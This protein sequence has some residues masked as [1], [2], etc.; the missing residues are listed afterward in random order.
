MK[1]DSSFTVKSSGNIGQEL[2]DA[3]GTVVCWTTDP[4]LAQ[5]IAR[6]LTQAHY[7]GMLMQTMQGI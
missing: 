5:V 4:W 2:I 6:L 7:N 3:N 1:Q